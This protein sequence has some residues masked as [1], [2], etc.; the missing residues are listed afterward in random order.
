MAVTCSFK[1]KVGIAYLLSAQGD[2]V[3]CDLWA[4]GNCLFLATYGKEKCLWLW[5]NDIDHLKR[6]LK[7]EH[8]KYI[9]RMELSVDLPNAGRLATLFAKHGIP[10]ELNTEASFNA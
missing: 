4:G 1:K 2:V 8:E 6:Y 5:F 9:D 10:C 7:G 3:P